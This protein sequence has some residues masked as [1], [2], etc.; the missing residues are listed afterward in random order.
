MSSRAEAAICD[1]SAPIFAALGDPTR[2]SIVARLS[3]EGPLS[4]SRLTEGTPVSRQAITKHLHVLATA[5]LVLDARR[6]R[7]RVFAL[8]PR[9]LAEARRHLDQIS[10]RWDR[11]I[12]RLRA[13]VER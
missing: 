10:A 3:H 5:G 8:E 6:G 9:P 4:I 13:M 7:E 2:L 1:R 12:H 11:A